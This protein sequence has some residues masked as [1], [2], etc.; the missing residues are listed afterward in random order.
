MNYADWSQWYDLFYSVGDGE[1]SDEA[2]F[3]IDAITAAD[4]PVL[5][6]GVGTGRIAIP[7]AERGAEIVGVD[8]NLEMLTVAQKKAELSSPMSGS[9][10]LLEAD[11]RTLDLRR[12]DFALV[13]LPA[14]V[15]L[16]ATSYDEQLQTLCSAARH[17]RPGGTLILNVFNPLT[18][19]ISD[20]EHEPFVFGETVDPDSGKRYRLLAVDNHDTE[21]QI[22]DARQIV[23]EVRNDGEA[24]EVARLSV[25]LRYSF[26]HEIFAMIEETPLQVEHLYG[27]F[28]GSPFEE[29]S[30]E[31]IFVCR[32]GGDTDVATEQR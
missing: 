14:R 27:D 21:A 13:I 10:T 31:M 18:D 4:G 8:A 17:V 2:S 6:I 1:T 29:D 5:E 25:R 16:L 7:A 15:L 24:V 30:E 9:L 12:K 28:S 22:N 23:E 32:K 20:G 3:Y 26:P 11:M 19:R